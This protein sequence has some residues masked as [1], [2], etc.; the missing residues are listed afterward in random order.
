[1][2]TR[3]RLRLCYFGNVSYLCAQIEIE[4][5]ESLV[6][7]LIYMSGC[8]LPAARAVPRRGEHLRAGAKLYHQRL[9]G[10]LPELGHRHLLPWALVC[11]QQLG[12]A[13]VRRQHVDA[14]SPARPEPA[15]PPLV[16]QRHGLFAGRKRGWLLDARRDGEDALHTRR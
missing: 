7:Y 5:D 11:R 6:A 1:M 2:G 12:A 10:E 4:T 16:Q 15:L 14:L 3:K 9:P 8:T 13:R